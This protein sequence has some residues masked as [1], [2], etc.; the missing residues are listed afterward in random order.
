MFFF[1]VSFICVYYFY[2]YIVLPGAPH[3]LIFTPASGTFLTCFILSLCTANMVRFIV[4]KEVLLDV[5]REGS[6][7]VSSL[8]T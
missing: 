3:Y 7:V 2:F 8:V 4:P 5:V 1:A 6:V